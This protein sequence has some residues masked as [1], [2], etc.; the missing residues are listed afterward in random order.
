M[1]TIKNV[2]FDLGGVIVDLE[3]EPAL[4][5]FA[6]LG[7]QSLLSSPEVRSE[8]H[9]INHR[10]D[11]GEIDTDTFLSILRQHCQSGVTDEEL[12]TAFNRVIVLPRHRLQR[13]TALRK[14]CRVYLLSNLSDLHWRET[15]RQATAHGIDIDSCFDEVFLSYRLKMAKPDP[16]IYR[17]LIDAT[18]I[19]PKETLYIDDLTENIRAGS[20]A[21]LQAHQI[22]CNGLDEEWEKLFP[23]VP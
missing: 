13:L 12:V 18:G 8:M 1:N 3:V 16:N 9:E 17:H 7:F 20:E 6:E 21:G 22:P 11:R 4:K 15:R 14:H 10:M 19:D 23:S 5:A 2:I